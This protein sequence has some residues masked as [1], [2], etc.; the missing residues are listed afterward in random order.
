MLSLVHHNLSGVV[1]VFD[2]FLEPCHNFLDFVCRVHQQKVCFVEFDSPKH[3]CCVGGVDV[4][5]VDGYTREGEFV[6]KG[7]TL[8][9]LIVLHSVTKMI[10]KDGIAKVITRVMDL[11]NATE[12]VSGIIVVVHKDCIEGKQ[13]I[14]AFLRSI[15]SAVVE[16]RVD[17][18]SIMLKKK[19]GKVL[20]SHEKILN[21]QGSAPKAVAVEEKEILQ[22]QEKQMPK[23]DEDTSGRTTVTLPFVKTKVEGKMIFDVED[24]KQGDYEETIDDEDPDADLEI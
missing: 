16:A 14:V 2:T 24:M 6:E 5:M 20:K 21:W 18:V 12:K 15:A 3:R 23:F 22:E 17:N 9:G 19:G 10:C 1:V 7:M 8:E 4:R 11:K 13:E